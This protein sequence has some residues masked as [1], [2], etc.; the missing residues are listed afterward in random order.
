MVNCYR[1]RKRM[2]FHVQGKRIG[3]G[4]EIS[5]PR[6]G[7]STTHVELFKR[8]RIAALEKNSRH[9][10]RSSFE[11]N[12]SF[13]SMDSPLATSPVKSLQVHSRWALHLEEDLQTRQKY[14]E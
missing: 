2:G 6:W 13:R 11:G 7:L 12:F 14:P 9:G 8:S 3:F 1:K 4:E 10:S 5:R